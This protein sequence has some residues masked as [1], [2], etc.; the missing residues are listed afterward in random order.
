MHMPIHQARHNITRAVI[1]DRGR[2]RRWPVTNAG[3]HFAARRDPAIGQDAVGQHKRATN[4]AIK[5]GGGGHRIL[6]RIRK[7]RTTA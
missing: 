2:D 5:R 6:L 3:N 4:D 1:L 7:N